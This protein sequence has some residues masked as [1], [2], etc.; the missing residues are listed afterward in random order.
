MA[1]SLSP[2]DS[3]HSIHSAKTSPSGKLKNQ[4]SPSDST[5]SISVNPVRSSGGS[6]TIVGGHKTGRRSSSRSPSA[7]ELDISGDPVVENYRKEAYGPAPGEDGFD[8]FEVRFVGDDADDPHNWSRVRRWY[9]TMLGAL[10][11][12]NS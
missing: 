11:V 4:A 8:A 12:L 10:L 1:A 2:A 6:S 7:A 5:E 3:T 9:I